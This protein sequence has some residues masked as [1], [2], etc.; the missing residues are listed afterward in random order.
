MRN[1]LLELLRALL[2]QAPADA[3][4]A[5]LA[6]SC[7]LSR[8]ATVIPEYTRRFGEKPRQTRARR[9]PWAR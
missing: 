9:H 1:R 7:G 5:E 4:I 2:L 3:T 8:M 6:R